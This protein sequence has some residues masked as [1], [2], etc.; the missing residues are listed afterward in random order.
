MKKHVQEAS[1]LI[2]KAIHLLCSEGYCNLTESEQAA[3]NWISMAREELTRKD[4]KPTDIYDRFIKGE[5]KQ[6]SITVGG[7]SHSQQVR[8][9]KATRRMAKKLR[10]SGVIYF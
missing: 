10:R 6:A 9:D 4:V 5:V 3:C 8:M 1:Q 7:A 2:G